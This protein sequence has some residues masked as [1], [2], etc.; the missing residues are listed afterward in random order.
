M[1]DRNALIIARREVE[2]AEIAKGR[3]LASVSH[4]LR[5]PLNSIIGFSDMLLQ[6]ICGKLPDGRQ[7][8]YVELVH[9]SGNHLLS[10]VNA[11]LDV[12]KI[13]A[14]TY[15]IVAESFAFKEAVTM[16][17]D[18][19]AHQASQKGVTL[20]DRV[21]PRIG[22]VVA[23]SRAINQ[24]L[25]NLVSNAVKFTESRRRCNDRRIDRR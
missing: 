22:N 11:I 3:F 21:S 20:C 7:R 14:G 5:T 23:D 15:P 17:H 18:M 8:E 13:E 4:E 10:V 24:V 2:T 16:V 25:I 6:E 1:A 9:R 19:M 12:S